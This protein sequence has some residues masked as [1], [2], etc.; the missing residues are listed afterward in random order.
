MAD[1]SWL[2]ELGIS[3]PNFFAGFCGGMVASIGMGR[4]KPLEIV[5][6]LVTGS[7]SAT[8][9]AKPVAAIVSAHVAEIDVGLAAFLVGLCGMSITQGIIEGV[10]RVKF[11]DLIARERK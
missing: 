5:S 2:A 1:T 4:T 8:Y 11:G 3:L 9:F 10:R 7:L 6:S